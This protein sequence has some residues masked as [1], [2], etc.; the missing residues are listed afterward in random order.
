MPAAS[1]AN[2]APMMMTELSSILTL[3]SG[4]EPV[5]GVDEPRAHRRVQD[6]TEAAWDAICVSS[7]LCTLRGQYPGLHGFQDRIADKCACI[8]DI[9]ADQFTLSIQFGS[10]AR[11]QAVFRQL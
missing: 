6:G 9:Y 4:G 8:E 10:D 5:L 3:L 2:P 1:P 11:A 7:S